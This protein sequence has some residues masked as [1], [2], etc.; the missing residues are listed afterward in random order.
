MKGQSVQK[1][2]LYMKEVLENDAPS[3]AT[4]Y[5]WTAALQHVQQ[6]TKDEHRSG[7]PSDIC[8]EK[9]VNSVQDT[10]LKDR[11]QTIRH[12]A[13]CHKL[14]YG[15]T[16]HIISDVLS[17]GKLA[18]AGCQRT[19]TAKITHIRMQTFSRNL[20]LYMADPVKFLRQ[21]VTMDET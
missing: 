12:V 4:V 13:E 8:T 20:E 17:Y 21:H 3:Q 6:S 14:S 2:H 18:H 10:I 16:H 9:N 19:L 7:R 1:I 15:T 5:R 11:R